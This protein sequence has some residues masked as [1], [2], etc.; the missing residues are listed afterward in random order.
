MEKKYKYVK[1]RNRYITINL[2][3][4]VEHFDYIHSLELEDLRKHGES[5]RRFERNTYRYC[6]ALYCDK[7]VYDE[8]YIGERVGDKYEYKLKTYMLKQ[9]DVDYILSLDA[10]EL[11]IYSSLRNEEYENTKDYYESRKRINYGENIEWETVSEA[12][13]KYLFAD[14][15]RKHKL[16]YERRIIW[17]F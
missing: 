1:Y 7:K 2:E 5:F 3:I 17:R 11:E 12:R 9:E 13:D 6:L 14:A 4:T 10:E 16:G 8:N 15:V